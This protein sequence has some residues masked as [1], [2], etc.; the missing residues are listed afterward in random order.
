MRKKYEKPSVRVYELQR[1]APL[2]CT[3]GGLQDYNWNTPGE[4]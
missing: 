4:E 2:V 3:S 1:H